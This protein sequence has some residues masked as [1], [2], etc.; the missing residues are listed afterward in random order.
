M[1]K[2]MILV[3]IFLFSLMFATSAQSVDIL[4]LK[5]GSVIKGSVKEII[6][7]EIVKIETADGSLFVYNMVDVDKISKED[8]V[9]NE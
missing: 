2:T 6:P 4:Y 1:T 3:C 5:N 9:K 8:A 7:T